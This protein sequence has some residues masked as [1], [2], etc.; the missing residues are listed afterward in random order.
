MTIDL[1][2]T[3]RIHSF[4]DFQ[5]QWDLNFCFKIKLLLDSFGK[6]QTL[7]CSVCWPSAV[8]IGLWKNGGNSTVT[9]MT[10]HSGSRRL[11]RCWL[12]PVPP[13]AAWT[14]RKPGCT[15]RWVLPFLQGSEVRTNCRRMMSFCNFYSSSVQFRS[16]R[17]RWSYMILKRFKEKILCSGQCDFF[18][19]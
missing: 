9:L 15:N 18:P 5:F 17:I 1:V 7:F 14:R 3:V 10:W 6:F 16:F 13:M 12:T 11:K 2:R 4:G 8:L 19:P